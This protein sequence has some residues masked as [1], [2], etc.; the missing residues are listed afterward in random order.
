VTVFPEMIQ[1]SVKW[2]ILGRAIESD[3]I[4]LNVVNLREYTH[5]THR[6][7]DDTIYGG[8]AGMVMKPEP[9]YEFYND[10]RKGVEDPHVIFPSP[11]GKRFDSS[12]AKRLADAGEVVFFCGRYEGI[13]ERVMD[14]VDEEISIG[15]FVTSGAELP[16]LIMMDAISRFKKG[17]VGNFESVKNDSFYNGLLDHSNYTRPREIEGK[18]VPEVYLNGNHKLIRE[19]RL[20]DSLL[21][22]ALKRPDQF[23][24][25]DFDSEEKKELAKLITELYENAE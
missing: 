2:G 24:R 3:L 13:D 22:T 7:T 10:F 18:K 8:G 23:T 16:V 1:E 5:D 25:R 11:Q 15:D 19:A 9:F 6:T 14:L 20:R 21:R 12:V 17:V 4:N